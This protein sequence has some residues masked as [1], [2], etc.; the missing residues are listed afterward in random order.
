MS[1]RTRRIT[2]IG[3]V[4]GW[5]VAIAGAGVLVTIAFVSGGRGA[6]AAT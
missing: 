5:V 1:E 6:V 2:R 3:M 4:A